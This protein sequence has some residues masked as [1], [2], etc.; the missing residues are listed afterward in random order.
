MK[1]LYV[2]RHAKSD[3]INGVSDIDRPLNDRGRRDAP[4]MAK[5]LQDKNYLPDIIITSTAT[6]THQ[7]R[8]LFLSVLGAI[9]T[10]IDSTLYNGDIEDIMNICIQQNENI[11]S[12]M[13]ISHNPGITYFANVICN[14]NLVNVP[15]CGILVIDIDTPSWHEL[16]MSKCT[17]VDYLYP[18]QHTS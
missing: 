14:A 10:E 16:D 13:T 18:K 6:R 12:L 15:T 4:F 7:T 1:R 5:I 11:N 17:L 9:P 2:V 3:W 8:D